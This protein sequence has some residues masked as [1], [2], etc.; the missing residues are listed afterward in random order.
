VSEKKGTCRH[1]TGVRA[2][3]NNLAAPSDNG[4]GSTSCS[5]DS[6]DGGP[7]IVY[8]R[9][10]LGQRVTLEIKHNSNGEIVAQD[11]RLKCS[12]PEHQNC[13]KYRS[14][15]LVAGL[16]GPRAAEFYLM[17]WLLAAHM[18]S[19]EHK[20]VRPSRAEVREIANTYGP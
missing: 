2:K 16:F 5:T 10:I 18:P 3:K 1:T 11:I 15:A 19:A 6:I 12:N 17:A 8:P 4:E 14:L 7:D 20:A 9:R 13:D